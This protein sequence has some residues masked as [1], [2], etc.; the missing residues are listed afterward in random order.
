MPSVSQI[1][2]RLIRKIRG[3]NSI[4]FVALRHP[5][6]IILYPNLKKITLFLK[7][8]CPSRRKAIPLKRN[9]NGMTKYLTINAIGEVLVVRMGR[10]LLPATATLS[11]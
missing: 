4:H 9:Q 10:V 7:I 3:T 1:K 6:F 8:S 2:I 5:F 11:Y